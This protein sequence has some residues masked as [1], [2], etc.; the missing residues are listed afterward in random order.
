MILLA[1]LVFNQISGQSYRTELLNDKLILEE[2]EFYDKAKLYYLNGQLYL[3]NETEN[4]GVVI[5]GDREISIANNYGGILKLHDDA[6]IQIGT[7]SQTF[8]KVGK[9]DIYQAGSPT[10]PHLTLIETVEGK[11]SIL[12][13][14]NDHDHTDTWDIAAKMKDNNHL[15]SMY[16]KG[17][18]TMEYSVEDTTWT[19][20]G[21]LDLDVASMTL[22]SR[23][24]NDGG[25][26]TLRNASGNERTKLV[27]DAQDG[28]IMFL[29]NNLNNRTVLIEAN[30][31]QD[32]GRIHLSSADGTERLKIDAD[33]D[34][35]GFARVVTDELQLNGGSDFAENFDIGD[36]SARIEPGMLVSID[37]AKPGGLIVTAQPN[38]TKVVGVISGAH[39]IRPGLLMG[40]EGSIADGDFPVALT[41]RV[42]V[43]T[44]D[45]NGPIRPGDFLTSSSI[46]GVAMRADL[47]RESY[48]SIIGKAMTPIVDGHVLVLVNLQ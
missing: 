4:F 32:A 28:G 7:P 37:P 14:R 3:E 5:K 8:G 41:G 25:Q 46:R 30:D 27:T 42:Y 45:E 18:A 15:F 31:G 29:Y 9:V 38:D 11:P 19:L 10:D 16:Y 12:S 48:G 35:S 26:L 24:Q 22:R 23:G 2:T 21:G 44:C 6:S 33:W 40:Q 34:N 43:K 36:E 20:M 39:G 17:E 13:F 1:L 47:A